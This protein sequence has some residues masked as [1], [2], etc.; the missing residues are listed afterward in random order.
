MLAFGGQ[1]A[2]VLVGGLEVQHVGQGH[3]VH[4]VANLGLE[5][6]QPRHGCG[7]GSGDDGAARQVAND[8]IRSVWGASEANGGRVMKW[9][10]E[11]LYGANAAVNGSFD[12]MRSDVE[13]GLTV[14]GYVQSVEFPVFDAMGNQTG[15]TETVSQPV[16]YFL[17]A[18]EQTVR[19]YQAGKSPSYLVAMMK[20]HPSSDMAQH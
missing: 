11:I 20:K 19:E 15:A 1:H 6:F 8:R 13:T 4:E 5:H 18:D 7:G 14:R 10:P 12:W 17:V 16:P 9:P 3:Q 2:H